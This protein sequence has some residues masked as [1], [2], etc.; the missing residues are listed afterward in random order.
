MVCKWCNCKNLFYYN[1]TQ[2]EEWNGKENKNGLNFK[3]KTNL[4]LHLIISLS[5]F[6]RPIAHDKLNGIRN[7]E[8]LVVMIFFN[9]WSLGVWSQSNELTVMKDSMIV[10]LFVVIFTFP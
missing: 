6:Q 1:L 3:S 8:N 2:Q 4:S 10:V 5:L 7:S 9:G